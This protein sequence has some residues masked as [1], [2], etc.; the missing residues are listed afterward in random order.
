MMKLFRGLL[1]AFAV[2]MVG[3]ISNAA[4]SSIDMVEFYLP[5]LDY[6]FITSRLPEIAQLDAL[7]DWQRTGKSFTVLSGAT[8][9][10]VPITRFF[11]PEVAK[12]STR[13]SHFYTIA[14]S[15]RAAL[16]GLNPSNAYARALPLDEKV[17]SYA[18]APLGELGAAKCPIATVPV[19][20]SFRSATYSPDDGNHRF[21]TDLDV[22][23]TMT[24]MGWTPEGIA[25]CAVGD[26][27]TTLASATFGDT[28]RSEVIYAAGVIVLTGTKDLGL[29]RIELTNGGQGVFPNS[30]IIA[31]GV[32]YKV[33]GIDSCQV[34]CRTESL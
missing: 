12:R 23:A 3:G 6:Y 18:Y 13:G 19:Y 29:G 11:F 10:T 26:S 33:S 27:V 7:P 20:R 1:C 21:T 34:S 28:V 31:D 17:D 14:D 32:A 8:D 16:R 25:F 9:G 22:Y 30:I 4:A 15:D 24:T 5:S 2:F